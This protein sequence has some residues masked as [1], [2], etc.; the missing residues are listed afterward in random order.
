[1]SLTE[2]LTFL[3]AL[4]GAIVSTVLA[5]KELRK[6]NRRVRVSCMMA[7]APSPSG[8]MWEFVALKAVNIGHRPVQITI[9]GLILSNVYLVMQVASNIGPSPLPKKL[10]DGDSVTVMLDFDEI[11]KTS[12]EKGKNAFYTKAVMQ[13][14]EGR[15]Y[16]AKSPRVLKDRGLSK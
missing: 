6:E 14:A 10:E 2:L 5:I 8:Q 3:I 9:A 1:M 11:V 12:N 4:Y 15:Q 16:A 7:M 13:D